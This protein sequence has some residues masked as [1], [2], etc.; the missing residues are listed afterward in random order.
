MEWALQI[1]WTWD[2][3]TEVQRKDTL[4]KEQNKKHGESSIEINAGSNT[5]STVY[6]IQKK[7]DTSLPCRIWK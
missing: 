4:T 2:N 3:F 1:F 7:G 6:C 5:Y